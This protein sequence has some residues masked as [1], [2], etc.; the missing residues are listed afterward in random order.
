MTKCEERLWLV[1]I[2]NLYMQLT[3]K[4]I[5]ARSLEHSWNRLDIG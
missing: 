4:Q 5:S 2:V 1:Q 3:M